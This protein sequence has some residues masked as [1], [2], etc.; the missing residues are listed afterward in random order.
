MYLQNAPKNKNITTKLF[1]AISD[2]KSILGTIDELLASQSE[3]KGEEERKFSKWFADNE[4]ANIEQFSE[5]TVPEKL[6]FARALARL[7]R[8]TQDN[9][10]IIKNH[11]VKTSVDS[12]LERLMSYITDAED[13]T[14]TT[15]NLND[16][17]YWSE[18]TGD[19]WLGRYS[20]FSSYQKPQRFC[21]GST[22][23]GPS[24]TAASILSWASSWL[25]T[26]ATTTSTT[27]TSATA[28]VTSAES[29]PA[30]R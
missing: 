23:L 28:Q 16:F 13:K 17:Y 18:S 2:C 11:T 9:G 5:Y 10:S 22:T 15:G 26:S 25:T 24:G 29:S 30:P 20:P 27:T 19:A 12:V 3:I 7:L 4:P 6:E 21:A 8:N 1:Q 14:E